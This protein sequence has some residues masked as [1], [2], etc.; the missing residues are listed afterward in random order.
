MSDLRYQSGF[1]SY[2]SS[3]ALEGTLPIG[4]NS[5]QKVN[6]GLYAEQLSSAAFTEPRTTNVYSWLYRIRPSVCQGKFKDYNHPKI[7]RKV[8]EE[9]SYHPNPMRWSPLSSPNEPQDFI[10][11]LHPWVFTGKPENRSGVSVS[12]YDA[13][14]S[15]TDKFFYNSDAELLIV[16]QSGGL[17]IKTELGVLDIEAQMIA[18]IPRGM[19][20]QV[21]LKDKRARGYLL[22]NYG[23]LFKT[24]DLGPIGANGLA[25][26]R[27]FEA[28][29]ACF[30]DKEGD[31]KLVNKFMNEFYVADIGHSPLDVVGWHGSYVPYRYDLRRFQVVNTVSFDHSDPSIFTV[32]TSESGKPGVANCDF[33]IFPPRWVV[34]ENTFRPPYFHR[35]IMSEFMGL[36]H[37]VYDAKPAGGFEPFGSSLHNIMSCHG[38]EAKAFEKASNEE[39]KPVYQGKTLAFM[40]ET[41]LPYAVTREAL[42]SDSFQ[43]NYMDCWNDMKK[44]YKS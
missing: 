36:I 5:P 18:I 31:F 21:V 32:L 22:E 1:G 28:P 20:F 30:E 24:P 14:L 19:K 33:V 3:E 37:G 25:M 40:F 41:N 15:M 11:S 35:N 13:S 38:P 10:D 44:N 17:E 23:Q 6:H 4:Q 34:S 29:V 9:G 42:D 26:P 8:F 43:E 12:L 16:P 39:L 2:F 27:D 7:N